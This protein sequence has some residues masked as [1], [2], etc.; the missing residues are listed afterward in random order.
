MSIHSY[1]LI[2]LIMLEMD[3]FANR[4]VEGLHQV[5]SKHLKDPKN[6]LDPRQL[7]TTC[8]NSCIITLENLP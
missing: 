2:I 1:Y 8:K 3:T 6:T 4:R 5:M 7:S